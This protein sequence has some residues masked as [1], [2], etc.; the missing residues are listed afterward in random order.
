MD[1]TNV[2]P[3]GGGFNQG[4]FYTRQQGGAERQ[5]T[6]VP[7]M[8]TQAPAVAPAPAA[9]MAGPMGAPA[10]V[11]AAPVEVAMPAVPVVGFLYSISRQGFG[12][13]W[14]L[15]V[16]TNTIGR[17]QDC[18][19]CLREQTVS[20]HHA[21]LFIRQ[22][23]TSR[24]II[25]SIRDEGSKNGIFVN[26]EELTYD[27][28]TCKNRDLITIGNNYVLLLILID[29][30]EMGL[31]VAAN[32]RP[33]DGAAEVAPAAP[34]P[35]VQQARPAVPPIPPIPQ[36]QFPQQQGTVAGPMSQP[37]P[38]DASRR[39]AGGTFAMDGSMEQLGGGTQFL[40]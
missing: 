5:G 18:D 26:Q 11:Q 28:F 15:H 4:G 25:A 35:A 39:A 17:S 2:P 37:S 13:Y 32:F 14:P 3:M 24:K 20:E 12:E 33:A 19:I 30:D 8:N 7:G 29:A 21:S 23:K 38:Y 10:P 27:A 16:G 40:E 6:M 31:S 1:K 9:P 36:P 22:M 34:Q